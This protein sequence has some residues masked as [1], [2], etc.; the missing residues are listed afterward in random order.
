ML[1][2]WFAFSHN[3]TDGGPNGGAI[4]LIKRWSQKSRKLMLEADSFLSDDLPSYPLLMS[5]I[6]IVRAIANLKL[7][8]QN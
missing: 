8:N 1:L 4:D 6:E 7:Y 2:L 3:S 5:V